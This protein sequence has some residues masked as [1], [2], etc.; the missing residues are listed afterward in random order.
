MRFARKI[1]LDSWSVFK[2]GPRNLPEKET[3]M[4]NFN[5]QIESVAMH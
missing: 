1:L 4:E 5:F 2:G 3:D